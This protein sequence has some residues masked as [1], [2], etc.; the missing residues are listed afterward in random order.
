MGDAGRA[1]C[2][3]GVAL[4]VV[5]AKTE[6]GELV[7]AASLKMVD[8]DGRAELGYWVDRHARR[9]GVA[10]AAV[11][12]LERHAAAE[13][14]VRSARLRIA[15]DN[16][17]SRKG[18]PLAL[19]YELAGPDEEL[20]AGLETVS[21]IKSLAKSVAAPEGAASRPGRAGAG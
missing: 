11:T 18:W 16:V 19:G 3:T 8:A 12:A 20:C 7:G 15:V 10:S 6:S 4:D 14:G 21:Y 9:E 13:L 17:A 5:V 2:E 1:W